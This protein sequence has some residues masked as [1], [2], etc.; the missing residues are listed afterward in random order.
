MICYLCGYIMKKSDQELKLCVNCTV[1]YCHKCVAGLEK[2]SLCG[3]KI[4]CTEEETFH[5][6]NP[7]DLLSGVTVAE[8][9]RASRKKVKIE[10][11]YTITTRGETDS[12]RTEHKALTKN[13]SKWGLCIYSLTPLQVG[14]EL[15]FDKCPELTNR[16]H[17]VVRWVKKVNGKIY[18]AGLMFREN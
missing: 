6:F 11:A 3:G 17:A 16:S 13:I 14:Q 9:R 2:C 8:K 15:R 10:C 7:T 12:N 18:V 5:V 1:Y 4:S